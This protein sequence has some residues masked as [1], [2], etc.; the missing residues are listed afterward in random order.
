MVSRTRAPSVICL[1][2]HTV[3][4]NPLK[5]RI[6]WHRPGRCVN[7]AQQMQSRSKINS[8]RQRLR[9]SQ[10]QDAC[11]LRSANIILTNRPHPAILLSVEVDYCGAEAPFA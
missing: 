9:I 2:N 5:R 1:A 11:A 3:L 7:P 10:K 8:G 6:P 4:A